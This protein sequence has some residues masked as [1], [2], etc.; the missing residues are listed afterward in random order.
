MLTNPSLH[1]QPV[2]RRLKNRDKWV[3]KKF[4][5]SVGNVL[6]VRDAA[7]RIKKTG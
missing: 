6:K 2:K 4:R 1:L 3:L 5:D 7:R